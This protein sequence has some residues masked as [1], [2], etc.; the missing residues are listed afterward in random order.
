LIAYATFR[1]FDA[2]LIVGLIYL[3]LVT[4]ANHLLQYVE[5]KVRIPG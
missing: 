5:Q 2:F 4:I 1:F 3:G